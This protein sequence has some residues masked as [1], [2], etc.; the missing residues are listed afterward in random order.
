MF[1]DS[2]FNGDGIPPDGRHEPSDGPRP[3]ALPVLARYYT[4]IQKR[5]KRFVLG[6]KPDLLKHLDSIDE[7]VWEQYENHLK[8]ITPLERAEFYRRLMDEKK[9]KSMCALARAVGK[10]EAAIRKY[11][12][13]L[14]LPEPIQQFLREHRTPTYVRYFTE[15]R[16]REL[17]K[18]ASPR[19]A[20]R[21]FQEMVA[22]ADRQG[23]SWTP[24]T[25]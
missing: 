15:E 2:I 12:S 3:R 7:S 20:W 22:E 18:L 17:L 6:D 24:V 25:P 8:R 1:L 5:Y 9:L 19:A 13:L 11:M 21:R 4:R 14:K 16:L 23:R 10:D